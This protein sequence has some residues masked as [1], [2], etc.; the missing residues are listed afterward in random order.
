MGETI[1]FDCIECGEPGRIDSTS[2]N[3]IVSA[4]EL[5]RNEALLCDE[6]LSETVG[7]VTFDLGIGSGHTGDEDFENKRHERAAQKEADEIADAQATHRIEIG[8]R[9]VGAD[10]YRI[11]V[12]MPSVAKHHLKQTTRSIT[13]YDYRRDRGEWTIGATEAAVEETCEVLR[14]NGWDVAVTTDAIDAA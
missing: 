11:D 6:H 14:E 10:E 5:T 9:Y 3:F 7:G 4:T 1:E 13:G 8:P 12:R 2:L